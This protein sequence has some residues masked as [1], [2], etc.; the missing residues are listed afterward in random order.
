MVKQFAGVL[1]FVLFAA[2]MVLLLPRLVYANTGT[3]P[4]LSI[5]AGSPAASTNPVA[6]GV[7]G[8]GPFTT[9]SFQ[10]NVNDGNEQN[11]AGP[12][13][14]T[15]Q[16]YTINGGGGL[17]VS[18]GAPQGYTTNP[19]T[20]PSTGLG[21][22]TVTGSSSNS[23]ELSAT[24][25]FPQSAAGDD[26]VTCT[27]ALNL[28]D[29]TQIGSSPSGSVQ[30]AAVA[31]DSVTLNPDPINIE[32]Q[33][34][35]GPINETYN[36]QIGQT[37][38]RSDF[39]IT[40]TPSGYGNY[41][42]LDS[43][44]GPGPYLVT[45]S[46]ESFT[47]AVGDNVV[48]AYTGPQDSPTSSASIDID[49]ISASVTWGSLIQTDQ[50]TGQMEAE[51]SAT[52]EGNYG[53]TG[54]IEIG[55]PFS[56]VSGDISP[57]IS[58]GDNFIGKVW[59]QDP[60]TNFGTSQEALT[61]T[62]S[63]GAPASSA[64]SS[65]G[66]ASPNR[67]QAL[68]AAQAAAGAAKMVA[69]AAAQASTVAVVPAALKGPGTTLTEMLNNVV[70]GNTYA[71]NV[72]S[73]TAN[74]S[75]MDSGYGVSFLASLWSDNPSASVTVGKPTVGQLTLTIVGQGNPIIEVP[76]V[77]SNQSGIKLTNGVPFVTYDVTAQWQNA[78]SIP[79][80]GPAGVAVTSDGQAPG[81]YWNLKSASFIGDLEPPISLNGV[82]DNNWG[83]I[84]PGGAANSTFIQG[85]FSWF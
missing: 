61:I 23:F 36:Y 52:V 29:G 11:E 56:P 13:S 7:S 54:S 77:I 85:T 2:S 59:L 44:D 6:V 73:Y 5:T 50:S 4:S 57:T 70:P 12:V 48:T 66:L 9:V 8:S 28:S 38:T 40:T 75:C 21:S 64:S 3:P 55:G 34:T 18:V 46:P 83:P 27:G 24:L 82:I 33:G 78:P 20:I 45:L 32:V 72:T 79:V 37:L 35:Y 49:G 68:Q 47:L 10:V 58:V 17:I 60:G 25:Y 16:Q 30:V 63:A 1:A 39:T 15:S 26:T 53:T 22:V 76:Q 69:N 84:P 43:N 74:V 71:P 51:Y 19:A 42:Y 81:D 62:T 65:A 80:E 41:Q 67:L 14:V 31:V